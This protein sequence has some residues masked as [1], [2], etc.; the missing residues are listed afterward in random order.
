MLYSGLQGPTQHGPNMPL[1]SY[2]LPPI[3]PSARHLSVLS[4]GLDVVLTR[5]FPAL[6]PAP[7]SFAGALTSSLFSAI[8]EALSSNVLSAVVVCSPCLGLGDYRLLASHVCPLRTCL[9]C[10]RWVVEDHD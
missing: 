8:P 3:V 5:P 7:L 1:A 4:D 10:V 6:P 2:L 9:S